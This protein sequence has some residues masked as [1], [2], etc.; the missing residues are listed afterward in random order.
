MIYARPDDE[1]I[2]YEDYAAMDGKKIGLMRA[3]FQNRNATRLENKYGIS[4]DGYTMT[5]PMISS[6]PWPAMRSILPCLADWLS[7]KWAEGGGTVW[8]GSVLP[9]HG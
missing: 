9:D 3:S 7:M 2:Y 1:D 5:L 6:R 4:L 8:R